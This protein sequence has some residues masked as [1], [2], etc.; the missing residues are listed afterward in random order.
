MGVGT[1]RGG[2]RADGDADADRDPDADGVPDPHGVSHGVSHGHPDARGQGRV[3]DQLKAKVIK[4]T[5]KGKLIIKVK[6]AGEVPTGKLRIKRN[7]KVL[8]TVRLGAKHQGKRVVKVKLRKGKNAFKVRYLG[9]ATVK[10]SS[11]PVR[12]LRWP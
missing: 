2:G 12:T 3:E 1:R 4:K 11:S 5:R 6:A 8:K 9:S 7:G 10:R